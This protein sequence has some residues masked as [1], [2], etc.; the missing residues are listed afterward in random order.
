[1]SD[2]VKVVL[3]F[4]AAPIGVQMM[5]AFNQSIALS[6]IGFVLILT[7]LIVLKDELAISQP[8]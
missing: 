7:G 2:F 3:L 5:I 8:F 6:W 1:M 4:F